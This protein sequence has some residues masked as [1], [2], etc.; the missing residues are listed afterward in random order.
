[1]SMSKITKATSQDPAV[2]SILYCTA[3]TGLHFCAQIDIAVFRWRFLGG[4][5]L[6]FPSPP[7][8]S[9]SLP[10]PSAAACEISQRGEARPACERKT[11][12]GHLSSTP[13][14]YSGFSHSN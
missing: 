11:Q 14:S 13:T 1:M 12:R 8:P 2:Q 10:F 6:P 7:F 5:S 3:C 4:V 9:P